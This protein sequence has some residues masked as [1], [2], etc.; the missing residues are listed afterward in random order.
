MLSHVW[1]SI[2]SL[3]FRF[4]PP[5]ARMVFGGMKIMI[6]SPI[7]G[8]S[9]EYRRRVTGV[10]FPALSRVQVL[11][12]SGDNFW[13]RQNNPVVIGTNWEVDDC[14]FGIEEAMAPVLK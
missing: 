1:L 9:V 8:E 14:Y 11:M 5:I 4:A 7:E 12:Y 6:T 3:T 13:Y 2:A 10:V